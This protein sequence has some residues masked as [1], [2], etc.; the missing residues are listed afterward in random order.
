M[1][2]GRPP[3]GVLSLVIKHLSSIVLSIAFLVVS[4]DRA[5]AQAPQPDPKSPQYRASG[6]Q[7][8]GWNVPYTTLQVSRDGGAGRGQAQIFDFFDAHKTRAK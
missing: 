5:F 1:L 6:E 2:H 8:R 3:P 4:L 7:D